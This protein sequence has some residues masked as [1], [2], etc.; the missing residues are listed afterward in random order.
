MDKA[1]RIAIAKDVLKLVDT[2]HYLPALAYVL[3][4]VGLSLTAVFAA[5]YLMRGVFA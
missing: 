4:S 5:V 1:K 3:L 2:H